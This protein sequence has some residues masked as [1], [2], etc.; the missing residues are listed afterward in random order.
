MDFTHCTIV[1]MVCTGLHGFQVQEDR[2]RAPP[3]RME[4]KSDSSIASSYILDS[5]TTIGELPAD[6]VLVQSGEGVF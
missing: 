2:E 3:R 6:H 5:K 1:T 4:G